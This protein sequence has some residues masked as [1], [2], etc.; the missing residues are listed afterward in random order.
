MIEREYSEFA[1]KLRLDGRYSTA[2]KYYASSA[3]GYL[4]KYRKLNENKADEEIS[5]TKIGY[6]SRNL[7]LGALCHRIAGNESRSE[8]YCRQG[9][10]VITDILNHDP[11]FETPEPGPPRG[12][13]YEIIGDFE[14]VA[15]RDSYVDS[16]GEAEKYY[17]TANDD[18][19][20]AAEPE[21]EIVIL[22]MINLADGV[23]Y[24]IPDETRGTIQ[25]LSL[26]ERIT[27]KLE[28]FRAVVKQVVE[29]GGW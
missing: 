4:M 9:I 28:N 24:G 5:P 12:L 13:C 14:L 22:T 16:Y 7:L 11:A 25:H 29:S 19:A 15:E 2:G 26:T 6:F 18:R 1:E 8:L 27:Y 17:K 23:D 21:F 20:W 10:L 3:Y